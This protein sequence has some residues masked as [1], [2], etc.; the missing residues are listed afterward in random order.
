MIDDR[1]DAAL[2]AA[3]IRALRADTGVDETDI[4]VAVEKRVVTLTGWVASEAE[5][6]AAQAAA[7][8]AAG[9]LDVANEILVRAP[10]ALSGTD[11]DLVRAVRHALEREAGIPAAGIHATASDAV[12]T[13]AGVVDTED[14]REAAEAAARRV[15]CVRRVVNE[16]AVRGAPGAAVRERES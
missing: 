13:L 16:I 15:A 1:H 4:G 10:F 8:R 9:V 7:H 3:V 6:A 12:V 2:K 11:A 5:K 14:A